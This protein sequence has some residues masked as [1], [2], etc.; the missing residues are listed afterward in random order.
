MWIVSYRQLDSRQ[1]DKDMNRQMIGINRKKKEK[2][3]V[4]KIDDID[5]DRNFTA[6]LE[7]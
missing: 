6:F 1:M 4:D 7:I 2:I 5:I 3:Q